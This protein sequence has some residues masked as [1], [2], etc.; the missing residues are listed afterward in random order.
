MPSRV[1]R[2]PAVPQLRHSIL[3]PPPN[4][5]IK[6]SSNPIS[7]SAQTERSRG[8][9]YKRRSA[10][11]AI[12]FHHTHV[13]AAALSHGLFRDRCFWARREIGS[14]ARRALPTGNRPLER[15]VCSL[16]LPDEKR[17]VHLSVQNHALPVHE[18]RE[19]ISAKFLITDLCEVSFLMASKDPTENLLGKPAIEQNQL[20]GVGR[21]L[22]VVVQN[23]DIAHATFDG[24][25]RNRNE[26]ACTLMRIGQFLPATSGAA[27]GKAKE[28]LNLPLL[29][30]RQR[31]RGV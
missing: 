4:K 16:L 13:Q 1:L 28:I 10:L 2:A 22:E 21:V 6:K 20:G 31:H 12:V 14:R 15:S 7:A 9:F 29:V 18:R 23:C 24:L 30:A 3:S 25:A 19:S 27:K 26:S 5:L 17:T 11:A 8:R